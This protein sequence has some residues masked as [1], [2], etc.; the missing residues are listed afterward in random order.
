MNSGYC[1]HRVSLA[2]M[3]RARGGFTGRE[4][5]AAFYGLRGVNADG[6][7]VLCSGVD[8]VEIE[9]RIATWLMSELQKLPKGKSRPDESSPSADAV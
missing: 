8:R 2:K 1:V 9:R 4:T 7:G 5:L 3:L 6:D